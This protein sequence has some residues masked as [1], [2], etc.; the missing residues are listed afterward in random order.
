MCR[1][2]SRFALRALLR[3]RRPKA[4]I[5]LL[6]R[7]ALTAAEGFVR[8]HRAGARMADLRFV[9]E[10]GLRYIASTLAAFPIG[11]APRTLPQLMYSLAAALTRKWKSL[12]CWQ[13]HDPRIPKHSPSRTARCVSI[14]R[15]STRNWV[16]TSAVMPSSWRLSLVCS[17]SLPP[18]RKKIDEFCHYAHCEP[19]LPCERWI[20][21][22]RDGESTAIPAATPA[23]VLRNGCPALRN[24]V[25]RPS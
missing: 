7:T 20:L 15:T 21:S 4:A 9:D 19:V 1:R 18:Y 24:Q 3:R 22:G 16:S 12:R 17:S 23:R 13:P 6:T 10:P 8:L 14:H 5:E 25:Q 2:W 11:A